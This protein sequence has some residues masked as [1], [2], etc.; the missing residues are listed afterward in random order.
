M[1]LPPGSPAGLGEFWPWSAKAMSNELL[2]SVII[3]F[4][5]EEK[6]IREA[7][8]SVFAQ[9]YDN[10]ELLLVDDGS[11][12][13]STQIARR[14]AEQNPGKVRYLEHEGHQNRGMSASRNLGIRH[15]KGDY[16]AFL[17]ADDVWL[18]HKLEQQVAI[19]S[20]QPE[21][22]MVCGPVQ[23]WYSWTGNP[24]DIQRD[25]VVAVDVQPDTL[26]KPP[27][28]LTRLLRRETVTTTGGLARR[29]AIE[30]VGGFE[31]SFHG[32]YEDLAFCAKLCSK[33]PVFVASRCW[34]K[35]RKHP[36][37]CCSVAVSTGQYRH[38]RLTFLHWL[39]KYLLEH[40]VKDTEV[41]E[42]LQKE[43]W[44]YRRPILY[45]PLRNMQLRTGK[46][47]ELLKMIARRTL[48]VPAR[49]WLRARW[50]GG[51]YCPPV[52]WVS[53]GSLRRVTP[54]SR[55]WGF[56]RGRPIDRYYIEGFLSDHAAD[57]RG[58][59]LE[60]GDNTYTRKFGGN[61]VIQSDVLHAIEGNPRATIVADLTCAEHIQA[62]TFDC[63]I[64]TQTLLF[65]YN[66]RAAIQT[67]YRILKPGGILLVTVAGVSH[68]ISRYDM[69]R[70]GDYWRFTTL[71]ARLLFEEVF[72]A[73]NVKVRAYG[74]VLAAMAFLYG[75]AVEDLRQEELDYYDPDYEA[76]IT[77]RAVKP[78]SAL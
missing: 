14:S 41:W 13:A 29:E 27:Q 43:L 63:I 58:R 26:V 30:S 64:C 25:Y 9:T 36:G 37:S 50:H 55:V 35:W 54:F 68:Q 53:F 17:D 47:K 51:E 62:D 32:L 23:W 70:W 3:I 33:A 67:L 57:I 18:P 39:E 45:R 28:L 21:A 73:A 71:S 22:A 16:I 31:E 46:M 44:Q 2:V 5:D 65:I 72:P 59:V 48:P 10:W 74:N 20:S 52:G 77:V 8:E 49:C 75:L 19:L 6:F 42:V 78:G 11:R 12:D 76:L 15:A 34:Y 4:L 69:D 60:I 40:Q 66:V 1:H 7:I 56:D 24:E 38:A 61:C